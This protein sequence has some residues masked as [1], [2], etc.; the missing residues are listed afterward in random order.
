MSYRKLFANLISLIALT[1]LF[2]YAPTSTLDKTG[3]DKIQVEGGIITGMSNAGK[4]IQIF[5]GIPFA[6]P[7]IGALRWKAPQ[8]VIP[9]SGEKKCIDFSASPMQATPK[10]FGPWSEAWLIKPSPINE[11]CLY[12]NIWTGAKSPAERRPVLVWIYGGGFQSG[13]GNVPLY[14]G[15]AMAKKGIIFVSVNY[16][17]GVFGFL[18]HP[19]LT[20]ESGKNASG[21][22]GLMDQIA[23][24]RWVQKN[25][26][27][28]GGDPDN[29]TIAGQSA[30][31][32]SVNCLVASP[33][34]KGL[35]RKAIAESGASFLSSAVRK[36]TTLSQ[37]ESNGLQFAKT[38]NATSISDLRK[39]S[40]E[41]LLKKP[42]MR[43][44]PIVDGYVL[45]QSIAEIFA[46]GKQND[47][48]LLTGWNDDD[49]VVF[50]KPKTAQEFKTQAQLIYGPN[51][52]RFLKFY[53]ANND[54]QAAESQANLSRDEIFGVQNYLWANAQADHSK[55]KVWVYRF[56]RKLPATGDYVKYGA[57]HSGEIPYAYNNLSLVQR[58]PW[59]SAD[60]TL[61]KN[62]S[63]YWAN[64]A[65]S[66]NPNGYGL[67]VW[68]A[69]NT[70]G[71]QTM[72]LGKKTESATLPGKAAL[73]FLIRYNQ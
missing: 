37:A 57:F 19:E 44:G 60:Y 1:V 27:A 52:A 41:E 55:Y 68:S 71:F 43:S 23:G 16:R 13:G 47:V 3:Q 42:F 8:P 34:C 15:E 62:M 30:G 12:L 49:G 56:T 59:I 14:D 32:M 35:F 7:P 65:A 36:T 28:F 24:I 72:L 10:P 38:C 46:A 29:I 31:S 54:K 48:F 40:A 63:S 33:L 11:D 25:I 58:C 4:D 39:M 51:A 70:T 26:A 64:F 5:K 53:P 66:G 73:D 6:A 67:P 2:S 9:W 18:A 21:N 20:S 17:V 69:Y 50:D 45:P 61:A 22:Y